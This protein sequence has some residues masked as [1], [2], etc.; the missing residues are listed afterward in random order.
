MDGIF[1]KN[2]VF[3]FPREALL[4]Q[5]K[6]SSITRF[7]VKWAFGGAKVFAKDQPGKI[8]FRDI[9]FY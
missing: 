7:W 4:D 8:C 9:K 1:F 2:P 3:M 6:N 5:V